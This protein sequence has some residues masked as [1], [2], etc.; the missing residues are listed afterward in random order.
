MK[1]KLAHYRVTL[2]AMLCWDKTHTFETTSISKF[3]LS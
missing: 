3:T 2:T 1:E